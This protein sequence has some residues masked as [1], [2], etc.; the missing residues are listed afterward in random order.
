MIFENQQLSISQLPNLEDIDFLQLDKN[1]IKSELIGSAIFFGI[2][3]FVL[4]FFTLFNQWWKEWYFW[5]IWVGWLAWA[6]TSVFF[7]FKNYKIAGYALR[8]K[9][10]AYRRGVLF[11]TITTIPLNR[12]QH[13]EI[14][15][16]PVEKMF[17]LA[18]LKVFTAG[19]SSSDLAISGLHREEAHKIK[20]FITQKIASDEEE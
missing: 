3:C 11:R 2:V 18:T 4:L 5:P 6:S 19:G 9:D 16:G 20:Q 13:C 7:A 10:I 17:E 8:K 14:T 15:E 12:M 1:Y